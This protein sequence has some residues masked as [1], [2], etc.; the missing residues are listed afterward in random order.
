MIVRDSVRHVVKNAKH[1]A[2]DDAA[3]DQWSRGIDSKNLNVPPPELYQ[4]LPSDLDRLSNFI[5]LVDALNFCFW[6][7]NPIHIQWRGE[8]YHRYNAMF[9]SLMLAAKSDPRWCD[10]EFWMIVPSEELRSV[11]SGTGNLL[12]LDERE[13]I[14]RETGRVLIERFDGKF[15]HAIESVNFQ[16]W[17]LAV[18]LMTSF[19]AF[20]DVSGYDGHPVFFMKRAQIC[21]VD[22]ALACRVHQHPPIEGLEELTAFADYRIPQ[23]LRHLQIMNL[24]PALSD[25]IERMDEIEA[26]SAEEVEIRAASIDA[27][28][29][30]VQSLTKH[31]K[32]CA[33]WQIDFYL[34]EHSHDPSIKIEHHR[35]RTIYY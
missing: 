19:D 5:L 32:R 3:I 11:L 35:T 30:M 29:Q 25:R 12:L 22:L 1:V 7:D 18:L 13:S 17:P 8:T 23:A 4:H 34:W 15:T 20:R 33:P 10:P 31:G 26:N 27:V 6:S 28:E 24:S 9:V 14:V 21:A 2:I 16:A